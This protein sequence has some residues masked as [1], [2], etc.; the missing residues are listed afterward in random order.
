MSKP[1]WHYT[2]S[3]DPFITLVLV[4]VL[5]FEPR[6]YPKWPSIAA[7]GGQKLAEQSPVLRRKTHL[8]DTTVRTPNANLVL[9]ITYD[10]PLHLVLMDLLLT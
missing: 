8:Q 10:H 3:F 6:Q 5:A 1:T 7:V 4:G 2:S 9:M